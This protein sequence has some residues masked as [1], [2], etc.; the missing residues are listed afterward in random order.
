MRAIRKSTLPPR[1]R[2]LIAA[3]AMLAPSLGLTLGS[4]ATSA[5]AAAGTKPRL[6]QLLPQPRV[7]THH[8][9]HRRHRHHHHDVVLV[10]A[11]SLSPT[12]ASWYYDGGST[13]CGFHAQYGVAN[14]TLPCGTHVIMRY[15]G[16]TV[17][18]TVD[19]RGPFIYGRTFDL[20][21]S[22][23]GALGMWGVATVY[24]SAV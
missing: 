13:A 19:D 18:A 11:V 10:S 12:V 2:L 15:G 16:H 20:S 17:V 1:V 3:L 6:T 8:R 21:Q 9:H 14:R 4:G 5:L 7:A 22:T 24:A 23:A